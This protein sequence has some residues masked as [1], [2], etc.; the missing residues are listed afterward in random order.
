MLSLIHLEAHLKYIFVGSGGGSV[1]VM[2]RGGCHSFMSVL[3]HLQ[4]RRATGA[5]VSAKSPSSAEGGL[6][7]SVASISVLRYEKQL[8]DQQIAKYEGRLKGS[9]LEA[10]QSKRR[11]LDS[12]AED[13]SARLTRGGVP[14]Q[15]GLS[16]T[17]CDITLE[18]QSTSLFLSN[19]RRY[20]AAY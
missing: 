7:P 10:L 8:L 1:V 17:Y 2:I 11:A 18:Q 15:S 16:H 19:S 4:P 3:L 5:D 13:I 20:C 9:E 12:Q 6:P 14:A